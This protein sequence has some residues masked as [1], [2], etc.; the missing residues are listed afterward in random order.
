M[1]FEIGDLVVLT[2]TGEQ[3][4]LVSI[5][6]KKN[7]TEVKVNGQVIPIHYDAIDH[8]YLDLF[9]KKKFATKQE[10]KLFID[11]VPVEK[12]KEKSVDLGFTNLGLHLVFVPV[13]N[14]KHF[15]LDNIEKVK[16]YL[17]NNT[18]TTFAFHYHFSNNNGTTFHIASEVYPRGNFYIHDVEF[19]NF[20]TGPYFDVKGAEVITN[21]LELFYTFDKSW[22]LKPK[23]LHQILTEM[24]QKNDAL[25]STA[26]LEIWSATNGKAADKKESVQKLETAENTEKEE[27]SEKIKKLKDIGLAKA[28]S[29]MPEKK[30]VEKQLLPNPSFFFP[31]PYVVDLHFEKIYPNKTDIPHNEKLQIQ[32]EYFLKALENAIISSQKSLV[33]IHGLGKG[34]LK[35]EIH[36]ILDQ[37]KEVHSYV[38]E[39]N[40]KFGFGSTEIFFKE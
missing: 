21:N 28:K 1:K 5:D 10:G 33:I 7:M 18:S 12:K 35:A 9:L 39:Y 25:F 4:I 19:E 34:V 16:I 29:N 20:A 31:D 8:P 17:A 36:G 40:P 24:L 32:L 3:G 22:Q 15:D 11:N 30:D 38:N 6:T 13:Y 26:L 37:T 23:K 14:T 2:A 27:I